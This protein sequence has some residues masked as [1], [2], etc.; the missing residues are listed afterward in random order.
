VHHDELA[1][2]SRA[3]G[4]GV[5]LAIAG[6]TGVTGTHVAD[7]A[8][9]RG[10]DVD[11]MSRETGVDLVSGAGLAGRLV[12]VD[13]VIDVSNV[14]TTKPDVSISFFA[15]GTRSLLSA[16]RIARVRHHIALTIVGADAA[17]DGYYAGKLVQ[18]RLVAEGP[19]PWT[20]LRATQFHE[21]AAMVF[22]RAHGGHVAPRGRVQPIAVREVAQHLVGLAESG[23]AGRAT[24]L[25]GPREEDLAE[26]VR[27]YARAIGYR[28]PVPTV[29][30]PSG[31][32]RALR[33]GALLP[34][35][36]AVVRRSPSGWTR[37]PTRDGGCLGWRHPPFTSLRASRG[38][39]PTAARARAR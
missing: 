9:S 8:R 37:C 26:M 27:A 30:V 14:V 11:V 36:D 24:D 18:E 2:P 19:V 38:R 21:Y 32:G 28:A 7:V 25:G 15:G 3:K 31:W 4:D 10:H 5:R 12:G 23:P 22:H 29:S 1:E 35:P 34:G 6:G 39:R 17:P 33:S 13:A 16:E 20:I